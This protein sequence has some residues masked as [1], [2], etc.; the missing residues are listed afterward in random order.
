MKRAGFGKESYSTESYGDVDGI[1]PP[2]ALVLHS[3]QII[4]KFEPL[5][6]ELSM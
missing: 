6:K 1:G 4:D 2:K 5:L 3:S